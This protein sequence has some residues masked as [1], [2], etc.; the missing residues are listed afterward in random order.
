M[1]TQDTVET[2]E[3]L[4]SA[5]KLRALFR[6]RFPGYKLTFPAPGQLECA[7]HPS[8]GITLGCAVPFF[9]RGV[10]YARAMGARERRSQ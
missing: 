3:S 5:I 10:E 2:A 7:T 1:K 4:A 6:E 8:G 9:W